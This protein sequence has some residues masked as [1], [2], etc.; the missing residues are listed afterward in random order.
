MRYYARK[1]QIAES[2]NAENRN[3]NVCALAVAKVLGVDGATIYLHT[4]DDLARAIRSMWSFRSVKSAIKLKRGDTIGSIRKRVDQHFKDNEHKGI[5]MYAV[6]VNGHVI[7]M[8][9]KG[10]TWVDTAPKKCDRREVLEI[11]GVYAALD[12]PIKMRMLKR[13]LKSKG[14]FK[15]EGVNQ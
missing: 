14:W 8:G 3:K 1:K 12:N 6:R 11:Y 9:T 7:L 5:F 4:W 2:N 13:F 10:Q 15:E